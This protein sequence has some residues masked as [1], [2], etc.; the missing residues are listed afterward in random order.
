MTNDILSGEDVGTGR[1]YKSTQSEIQHNLQEGSGCRLTLHLFVVGHSIAIS[2]TP[3]PP[4]SPLLKAV[5]FDVDTWCVLLYAD[6][7]I[8]RSSVIQSRLVGLTMSV[9]KQVANKMFRVVNDSRNNL[10][11][12]ISPWSALSL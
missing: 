4:R 10:F 7:V 6:S 9:C 8:C 3:L 2:H 12:W 1:Q 5:I 11:I